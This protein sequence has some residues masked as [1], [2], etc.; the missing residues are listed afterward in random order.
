MA[1]RAEQVAA[2]LEDCLE[3][4]PGRGAAGVALSSGTLTSAGPVEQ[5]FAWASV[6]KLLVSQACLVAVEEMI[7]RLDDPCG[8]DGSTLAHLLAHTSGLPFEGAHP[9]APP[10]RRRI[11]SNTGIVLAAAHLARSAGMPFDEYLRAGVLEP[12]GMHATHLTGS[13]AHSA[14]G[15]LADLLRFARE[16]LAPTLVS[17]VTWELAT[18]VA[19][20]GLAGV[21][22]GFG[23][24]DNCDWGL[25]PEIRGTK[26]PH[27]T[28]KRNSPTT[29][30]HFGQAGS[31]LWVD[32]EAEVALAGLGATP[33]G[34]WA[35]ELWPA[36]ADAVLAWRAD[37][38]TGA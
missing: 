31:L 36:L 32:P 17:R 9:V 5:P 18:T 4:W 27:W 8:P 37:A 11:Y 34:P 20:P 7:V 13:A 10:A 29:F 26:S 25:G 1:A 6:T 12:L 38:C 23:R 19:W 16:L 15:P 22:P 24:Y 3:R 30:G 2:A 33:F 21:V 35:K 28:G 14:V